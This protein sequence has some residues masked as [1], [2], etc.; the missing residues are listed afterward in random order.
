MEKMKS[1]ILARFKQWIL[2]IIV[3]CYHIMKKQ[4]LNVGLDELEMDMM[5]TNMTFEVYLKEKQYYINELN[6]LKQLYGLIA[7]EIQQNFN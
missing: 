4:N 2:S 5:T 1:N 6:N 3:N 7:L